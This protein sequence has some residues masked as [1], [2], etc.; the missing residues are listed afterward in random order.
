MWHY[1]TGTCFQSLKYDRLESEILQ[2]K[3]FV[4]KPVFFFPR[5][6]KVTMANGLLVFYIRADIIYPSC[7]IT[8]WNVWTYRAMGHSTYSFYIENDNLQGLL[9]SGLAKTV[10]A[11]TVLKED[12][13]WFE[14]LE[15]TQAYTL[16]IRITN[17]WNKNELNMYFMV[18][19]NSAKF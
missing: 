18:L 11:L 19:N 14:P 7:M 4:Q 8:N 17:L 2:H 16:W 6:N 3:Q 9:N 10:H 5:F 15:T 13:V 12:I 1:T